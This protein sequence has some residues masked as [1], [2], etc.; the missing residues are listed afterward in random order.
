MGSASSAGGNA[1]KPK[2]TPEQIAAAFG[3]EKPILLGKGS[4]G[5]TWRVRRD[6]IAVA[7]KVIVQDIGRLD[8][9]LEGLRRCTSPNVVRLLRHRQVRIG[10]SPYPVL[11]FEFVSGGSLGA[12]MQKGPHSASDVLDLARGLFAGLVDLHGHDTAHRDIKPENIALRTADLSS[13]VILDLGL[14]KLL[15]RAS[16]TTYPWRGG[17]PSYMAP[18]QLRGERAKKGADI[19]AVGV[20]LH[21]VY[22]GGEHPFYPRGFR[23][24]RVE[25]Y[26]KYLQKPRRPLPPGLHAGLHKVA[27]RALA[28]EPYA[29]GSA[30]IALG[31]LS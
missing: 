2:F 8:Q 15:D 19:W 17:T 31:D 20:V 9:E 12:R 6:G 10:G 11:E 25:D 29:R 22:T 24:D 5:E 30:G 14:A 23:S 18:E 16:I 26:L 4:F 7:A 13:P 3:C 21:E 27:T 1:I 28:A